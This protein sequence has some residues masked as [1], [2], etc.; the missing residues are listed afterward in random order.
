MIGYLFLSIAL[1]AGVTKGYCGKRIS[2]KITTLA[3]SALVNT[4]RMFLCIV[5]GLLLLF[6]QKGFSSLEVSRTTLL[7][8]MLSGVCSALFVISWLFAV[9]QSAYMMV[10][11]FLL[12][13]K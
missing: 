8:S 5:I 12:D 3:D 10:E 1:I 7:I 9:K 13:G 11:V 2:G 6:V 4:V